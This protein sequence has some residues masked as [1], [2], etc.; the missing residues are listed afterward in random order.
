MFEYTTISIEQAKSAVTNNW[1]WNQLD[2]QENTF[3]SNQQLMTHI[4]ELN[5]SGGF[6]HRPSDPDESTLIRIAA[7]N[8]K[9]VT[10]ESLRFNTPNWNSILNKIT[11]EEIEREYQ[12]Y[13]GFGSY[14]GFYTFVFG[15]L[16]K[17]ILARAVVK[18]WAIPKIE[19]ALRKYTR[20]W[21]EQKFAPDGRGFQETA[22]HFEH[23]LR[24]L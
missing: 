18:M 14:R 2:S 1:F 3:E 8:A 23:L 4:Y 21:I 15:P 22:K 17:T 11:D 16:C 10:F 19:K 6:L 7:S 9:N 5:D 13:N 20:S 12:K 24:N